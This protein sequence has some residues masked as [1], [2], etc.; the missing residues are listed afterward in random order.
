MPQLAE[1]LE[2][3][4]WLVYLST[5]LK[6]FL[7]RLVPGLQS[8]QALC[9]GSCSFLHIRLAVKDE[10]DRRTKQPLMA[11]ACAAGLQALLKKV[12]GW[13]KPHGKL[14]VHHFCHKRFF[15]NFEV[16]LDYSR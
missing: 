14:F 13:L 16:C 8:V 15:Y 5:S 4:L 12:S 11:S 6:L 2:R 1:H 7:E 3:W 9:L 10:C